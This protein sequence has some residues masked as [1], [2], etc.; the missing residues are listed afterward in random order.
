MS[1]LWWPL[2]SLSLFVLA[3]QPQGTDAQRPVA[4]KEEKG[5]SPRARPR[6]P[7]EVTE[8]ARRIHREAVVVDGH[9][10]LP[11]QFRARDD[12]SFRTIDLHKR[13]EELHTDLP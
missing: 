3:Q 7:V 9:N 10:D 11:W 5:S 8:E 13:Q 12:L 1:K 4:N 6:G 2:L